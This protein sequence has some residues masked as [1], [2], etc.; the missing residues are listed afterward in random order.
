MSTLFARGA[1]D[2]AAPGLR[3]WFAVFNVSKDDPDTL[4]RRQVSRN[5][6]REWRRAKR[7]WNVP[8]F[9][10]VR[11]RCCWCCCG[12]SWFVTLPNTP[13]HPFV[14][15]Y[16]GHAAV[17]VASFLDGP[18]VALPVVVRPNAG[19]LSRAGRRLSSVVPGG[20][21]ATLVI[22]LVSRTASLRQHPHTIVKGYLA[23]RADGGLLFIRE[24][25]SE[26]PFAFRSANV[27]LVGR[28]CDWMF[29]GFVCS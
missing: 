4:G 20:V 26:S 19:S 23:D 14:P 5:P 12:A 11:L 29:V 7:R 10:F 2:E 18:V 17:D 3:L 16:V 25:L 27:G 9:E 28:T 6:M 13:P 21:Q 8:T 15:Q 22:T 1:I 24:T